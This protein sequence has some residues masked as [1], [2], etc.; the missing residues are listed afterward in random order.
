[1]LTEVVQAVGVVLALS[2]ATR[3]WFVVGDNDDIVLKFTVGNG[4]LGFVR[5]CEGRLYRLWRVFVGTKGVLVAF[6]Q[7]TG[8]KT[9]FKGDLGR[10]RDLC[11]D[12][13]PSRGVACGQ[14]GTLELFASSQTLG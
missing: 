8:H 5:G 9:V 7:T 13:S 4:G 3:W 14:L 2:L 1:M 12:P 10:V 6:G 11:I